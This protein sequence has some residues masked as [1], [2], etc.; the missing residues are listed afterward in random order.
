LDPG[1]QGDAIG[2]YQ[3]LDRETGLWNTTTCHSKRCARLDCHDPHSKFKLLGVFKET[4]GLADWAEQLFKHHAYCQWDEDTYDTMQNYR[5]RWPTTCTELYSTDADGKTLFAGLQPLPEGNMTIG[6]YWDDQCLT[7]SGTT[8]AEYVVLYYTSY[9]Y[10]NEETG[11]KVASKW[12]QAISTWNAAMEV[13]KTCQ[14]CRAYSISPN[15]QSSSADSKEGRFL[16]EG[17]AGEGSEEPWGY[18]CND[19]AG[20]LNCDQVRCCNWKLRADASAW[21]QNADLS[22]ALLCS[23][24][25][26]KQRRIWSR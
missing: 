8:W 5:E 1:Y 13:Y 25:N 20:Y 18:D 3:F 14:P 6:V 7:E 9:Y 23:A 15:Q 26:L 17:N 4:D 12:G 19:D 10:G 11:R 24:T 16:D 21:M 22:R 2:E